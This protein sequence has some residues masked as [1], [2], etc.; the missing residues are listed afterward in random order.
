MER[1]LGPFFD[2]I[3]RLGIRYERARKS[4]FVDLDQNYLSVQANASLQREN[5]IGE[6]AN[7]INTSIQKIQKWGEFIL[8]MFPVPYY[9][10]GLMFHALK[11]EIA[12]KGTL[13]VWAVSVGFAFFRLLQDEDS[14][15][16]APIT[17]AR[18]PGHAKAEV[19]FYMWVGWDG[20]R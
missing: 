1:R 5:A 16:E 17:W 8:L 2:Y 18:G 10:S 19:G 12:E 15:K 11:E 3:D 6:R 20:A 7:S 4:L 14:G 9:I 13:G